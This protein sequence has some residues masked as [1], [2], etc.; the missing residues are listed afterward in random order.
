MML[1]GANAVGYTNY[2]D[3]M[4]HKFWKQASKSGVNVSDIFN[5]LDYTDN[6]KLSFD[7]AG[8]TGGFVEGTLSYMGGI[9]DHN[10]GKYD[11]EYRINL[12]RDIDAMGVHSLTVKNIVGLLTPRATTTLILVL[13]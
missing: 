13:M 7:A 9:L 4:V 3:S 2:P 8:S 11:I 5:S 1:R 6:L 12:A 10:K